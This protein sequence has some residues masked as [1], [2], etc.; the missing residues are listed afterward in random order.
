[1]SMFINRHALCHIDYQSFLIRDP[2]LHHR[3]DDLQGAS[4]E[5][6]LPG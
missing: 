5:S 2:L 3:Q 6:S 1:M 4:L